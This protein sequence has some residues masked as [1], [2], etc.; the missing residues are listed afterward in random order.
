[1]QSAKALFIPECWAQ[2]GTQQNV[3]DPDGA[4]RLLLQAD[5]GVGGVGLGYPKHNCSCARL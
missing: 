2:P 1:M 4:L 3:G 5:M